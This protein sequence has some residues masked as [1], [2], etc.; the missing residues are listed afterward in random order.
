MRFKKYILLSLVLCG[1]AAC[2]DDNEIEIPKAPVLE[3]AQL[4]LAIKSEE[5]AVTKAGETTPT[6]ADVNTL[7]VGVFGTGWSVVYTKDAT[8]NADG[9][10]D[11]GPQEVYAGE[12]QVV[13]V[14]N[15]APA[16][17]D[18]LAKAKDITDFIETTINLDDETLTKGLT[19]SSKVFT[20]TLIANTINYIG[21]AKNIGDIIT[22][23]ETSG[24]EI[25]GGGPVP[26]IRNVASIALK[27]VE[28]SNPENANYKSV[29][30][31]LKE[32]F[33]ASAKG[34]SS[35]ASKEE[36]G[37]IEKIIDFTDPALGYLK[38]MVGREF[39]E[40][41]DEGS[42]K[43]GAQA[44]KEMLVQE[45]TTSDEA[46]NHEFYV[47][48]NT[49][50]EVKS[51]ESN[52][53]EAY[54]NHTL[55]IVKGDYTYLPQGAKESITKENCYYAI[56]VGEEVTIDGTERTPFVGRE[57]RIDAVGIYNMKTKSY[58][59]SEADWGETEAPDAVRNS[60]DTSFED[61]LVNDGA[62]ISNTP[63]VHYVMENM[64]SDDH[65]MIAVKATLQGN[66]SYQ[67]HTKI[68][69][70]VINAGGLQNGYDHNFIRRNYVYR[71]RIYFDGESFDNIP[72]T[73]DP[74]PDPDPEPEVDT[75]LNIAVQ[76]VG[77][78]PVVQRP[79]ID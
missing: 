67:D 61:L 78:G 34:V 33:I 30:F 79:V 45:N 26:L 5:G 32:V 50:G 23:N 75:N 25:C 52:V 43:K 74:T 35:V 9:T 38:Y 3:K 39:S 59:F 21:Y 22:I 46:L 48:E 63:F 2:S 51:G 7:T 40:N 57:V 69:T 8:S 4:A 72:V 31:L 70:A 1:F 20:V 73:P 29:S 64:K 54:A 42:Y 66:S 65:T 36:W 12:A 41:I 47:Y 58:Y 11:V 16:I 76:V 44:L 27:K 68:F 49:K 71:L 24:K 37:A 55:L 77:W 19:M 53:N 56:P 10:K 60:E 28:T 6:D 13:V 17:Q 15:A 18:E 62:S 14:A